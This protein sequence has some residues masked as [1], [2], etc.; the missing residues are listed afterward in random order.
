MKSN[1]GTNVFF[2]TFVTF[3]NCE[4]FCIEEKNVEAFGTSRL[5][6]RKNGNE[7]CNILLRGQKFTNGIYD[8]NKGSMLLL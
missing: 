4:T 8:F 5:L 1:C 3:G 7:S 6:Y 2:G